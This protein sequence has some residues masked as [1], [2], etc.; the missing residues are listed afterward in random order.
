MEDYRKL[1]VKICTEESS[2]SGCIIYQNIEKKFALIATSKH[3]LSDS[4]GNYEGIKVQDYEDYFFKIIDN[5]IFSDDEELDL[6]IIKV[7]SKKKYPDILLGAPIR[8]QKIIVFGYPH[9]L[10]GDRD[11]GELLKGE[12]LEVVDESEG[13]VK[14]TTNNQLSTFDNDEH[15]NTIGYSG[16]AVYYENNGML[17]LVG[18]IEE[19]RGSGQQNGINA[20]HVYKIKELVQ[21]KLHIYLIPS[22]LRSFENYYTEV[23]SEQNKYEQQY[24][25]LPLL[26]K[27]YKK[28]QESTPYDIVRQYE[29]SDTLIL[30]KN[31]G[32]SITE[33]NLWVGWLRLLMYK[34]IQMNNTFK[35]EH[36]I[37]S[38]R[39]S[40]IH[41]VYTSEKLRKGFIKEFLESSYYDEI[42][43]SDIL[44]V[45]NAHNGFHEDTQRITKG[46]IKGIVDRIDQPNINEQFYIDEAVPKKLFLTV[47]I[48]YLI[49]K[50]NG[51]LEELL[52]YSNTGFEKKFID[53]LDN[54]F[55]EME[56]D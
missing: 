42:N 34:A 48:Q 50:I 33:K 55:K 17:N 13:P 41:M 16:S 6:A 46:Q 20:V 31:K 53:E 51:L 38:D 44:F 54:I 1:G 2:G 26:E 40:N 23:Y 4:R 49:N 25:I 15:E 8:D 24:K 52:S 32:F 30:S 12:I 29:D 43:M 21:Q 22:S 7:E 27:S 3:C 11:E 28:I 45:S 9:F 35:I 39:N 18:I 36:F 47:H 56:E 5:P 10:S 19:L 37:G 14:L